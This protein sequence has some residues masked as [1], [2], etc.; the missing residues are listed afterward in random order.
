M[1]CLLRGD[2]IPCRGLEIKKYPA[3]GLY[4][5]VGVAHGYVTQGRQCRAID[6]VY[7][8]GFYTIAKRG[9]VREGVRRSLTPGVTPPAPLGLG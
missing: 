6:K 3:S 4:V 1:Y 7:Y 5:F 8:K 2:S 9:G